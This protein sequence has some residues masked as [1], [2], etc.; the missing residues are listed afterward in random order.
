RN[1]Q[2]A[3][4]VARFVE[5]KE[6]AA[7]GVQRRIRRIQVLR[8]ALPLQQSSPE[9]DRPPRLADR[10]H[11]PPAEP[12]VQPLLLLARNP[13]PRLFDERG[14]DLAARQRLAQRIP[15]FRRVTQAPRFRGLDGDAARLE[16]LAR[17]GAARVLPKDALVE[18]ACLFVHLG[19]RRPA[20]AATRLFG[21][22]GFEIDAG[23]ASELLGRL[24]KAL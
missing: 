6:H 16:V 21:I 2:G 7:L 1:A 9:S 4:R 5:R 10:N 13:E 19:Q 15:Q 18:Y 20:R 3:D 12:V 8:L 23:L 22:L 17:E 14:I 11:Q 24:A